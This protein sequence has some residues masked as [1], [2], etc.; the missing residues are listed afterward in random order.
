MEGKERKGGDDLAIRTKHLAG[1]QLQRKNH[2]EWGFGARGQSLV[3]GSFT[4]VPG[5][6]RNKRKKGV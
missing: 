4:S 3:C 1:R 2:N 6:T 5:E